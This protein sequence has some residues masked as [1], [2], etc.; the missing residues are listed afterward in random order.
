[1]KNEENDS[2]QNESKN[3]KKE[4]LMF[5]RDPN[6]KN[7]ISRLANG[8]IVML[9]RS[10]QIEPWPGVEYLC[11]VQEKETHALSWILGT[12]HYPRIV[13]KADESCILIEKAEDKAQSISD[14]YT[15]LRSLESEFVFVLYRKEN[16]HDS[17]SEFT[18][19]PDKET[20]IIEVELKITDTNTKNILKSKFKIPAYRILDLK[21]ITDKIIEKIGKEKI[22]GRIDSQKV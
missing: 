15:A 8:K 17:L 14:I 22:S 20:R 2:F 19:K 4:T 13:V 10:C 1:M 12:Y 6:N 18:K 11:T 3:E 21:E 16:R 9:H 7:W 5:V